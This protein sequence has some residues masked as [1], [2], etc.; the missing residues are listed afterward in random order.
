VEANLVSEKLI[1]KAKSRSRASGILLGR[2]LLLMNGISA[3]ALDSALF[4]LGMVQGRQ[5]NKNEAIRLLQLHR[6]NTAALGS[7]EIPRFTSESHQQNISLGKLCIAG[8]L[9]NEFECLTAIEKSLTEQRKLGAVLIDQGL[10]AEKHL[11][12]ALLLQSLAQL[13]V[14]SASQASGVLQKL[15][16]DPSLS[17]FNIVKQQGLFQAASEHE[18]SA[19][20]IL[21]AASVISTVDVKEANA[22]FSTYEI[23][24]VKALLASRRL[25]LSIYRYCL[26]AIEAIKDKKI[27]VKEAVAILRLCHMTGCDYREASISLQ[28]DSS[29]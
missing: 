1:E 24:S 7:F 2:A 16:A 27:T 19:L 21:R 5:L 22:E 11:R 15:H 29:N 26:L 4:A 8:S 28:A 9:I 3:A 10:V 25:A 12:F 20:F 14:V 6:R 18:Y 13:G 17:F 23:S